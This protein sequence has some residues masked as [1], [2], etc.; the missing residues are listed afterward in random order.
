MLDG[1]PVEVIQH[2]VHHLPTASSIINLSLVSRK[3]QKVIARDDYA[4]FRDFVKRSF[5]SIET[6]PLW[7]EAARVL[8][9]RSRAWDRRAFVA[10]ECYPP[11]DP[12]DMAEARSWTAVGYQPVIDCYETWTGSTWSERKEVLAWGAAGKLRMRVTK[13]G[14][15]TWKSFTCPHDH[16]PTMDIVDVNLLRPNQTEKYSE[17]ETA[18]LGRI[19]GDVVRVVSNDSGK[20]VQQSVYN[21]K[22]NGFHRMDVSKSPEPVLATCNNDGISLFPVDGTTSVVQPIDT[23][24]L[25]TTRDVRNRIR[26]AKFLS[27]S[28]FA[29]CFQYLEGRERAP[30]DVY[31]INTAGITSKPF[32]Q[33]FSD[34]LENVSNLRQSANTVVPLDDAAGISNLPGQLFLSGWS[35]GIVSLHDARTPIRPVSTYVDVVDDGQILAILPI[36][37]ERFL[38]GSSQN[39]CLKTYDLRMPGMRP[40][41][42]LEGRTQ[43][44]TSQAKP[45]DA[46]TELSLSGSHKTRRDINIFLTPSVKYD[47]RL[48]EPLRSGR[49]ARRTE[50]YRGCV[51]S[52]ASPSPSSPTVYAGIENHVLQL[53]FVSTDDIRS[54]IEA[55][56]DPVLGLNDRSKDIFSFSCYERPREGYESTDP[57]LLRKQQGLFG[58]RRESQ[59]DKK[60]SD[61][62]KGVSEPGWDE[63]WRLNTYSMNRGR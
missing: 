39:G 52:L 22:P 50:R 26:C 28:A 33:F 31:H 43:L 58:E 24:P 3:L 19:S 63:R 18:I 11:V 29:M 57:V 25:Q 46:D 53:D 42:Y 1:L 56:V 34:P 13:N 8:T 30:I 48:W 2:I 35:D 45:G 37:H 21:T 15:V 59:I 16:V 36:G 54:G 61:V 17:H 44:S 27:D 6:P 5:P 55:L 47:E 49:R 20:L 32:T 7:R 60:E 14:K 10:R 62:S 51:Y 38:A 23:V 12:E 41:S 4:C 40:Y 9:S